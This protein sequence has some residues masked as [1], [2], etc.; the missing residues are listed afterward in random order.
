MLEFLTLSQNEL[1]NRHGGE[2]DNNPRKGIAYLFPGKDYKDFLPCEKDNN[3][4]KGIAYD[5]AGLD[6]LSTYE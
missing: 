6:D 5:V 2:K 3:P 1:K 4:R